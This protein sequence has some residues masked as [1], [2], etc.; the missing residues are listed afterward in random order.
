MPVIVV[1]ADTEEGRAIIDGLLEPHREV[2]AFVSDIG[3]ASDLK[4][5]GV[6]VALGDVSDDSHLQVAA[7]NCFTAVLVTEAARD[8]RERSF[9]STEERV[10]EGW[11]KA[12]TVSSVTRVIW[13]HDGEVPATGTREATT[14]SPSHP[15]LVAKV[16]ALDNARTLT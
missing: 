2:R 1:G 15:E 8:D 4:R 10:L 16:V 5:S 11:A 6:K 14:V 9:A 13:V 3:V 12:V 7:M